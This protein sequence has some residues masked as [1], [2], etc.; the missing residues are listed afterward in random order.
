MRA[1]TRAE[2][3]SVYCREAAGRGLEVVTDPSPQLLVEAGSAVHW[4]VGAT[5]RPVTQVQISPSVWTSPDALPS[6]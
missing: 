4:P 3:V 5:A 1:T 6:E 2:I